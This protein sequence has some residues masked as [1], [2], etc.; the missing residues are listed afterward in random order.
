[1]AREDLKQQCIQAVKIMDLFQ[2]QKRRFRISLVVREELS[3][4]QFEKK[5]PVDPDDTK[6]QR[7]IEEA[8]LTGIA[9]LPGGADKP[10][11]I[12]PFQFEDGVFDKTAGGAVFFRISF[13]EFFTAGFL[14][15]QS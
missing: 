8:L 10:Q 12:V 9:I 13:D 6:F 3:F 7:H 1:M 11:N 4:E 14:F 2:V 15:V 5:D